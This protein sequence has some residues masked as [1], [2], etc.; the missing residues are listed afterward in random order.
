VFIGD[1]N[2]PDI[3]WSADSAASNSSREVMEAA[4]E[5]GLS[6]L[7]DFPTHKRGNVLD[8]ILTNIPG[9]MENIREEASIGR[10]DHV[11]I[12]SELRMATTSRAMIKAKNW[13][14]ADWKS[15][16]EGITNT[17][18]PTASDGCTVE[19]AWQALRARINELTTSFVPERE[20]RE[21]KSD[22][23][24][25][26][27]LQLVRK[28]R[29]MWKRARHG[30]NVAKYEDLARTVSKK[31]RTAK[32]QMEQKLAKDKTGN[33]KPFYNYIRKKTKTS[34]NV[35][36]LKNADGQLIKEPA[37]MAEELN[38]CFSDVFTRENVN[39]LP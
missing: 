15:I 31:I 39:N 5:A 27:I 9:R 33:K 28:K 24:T 2:L 30:Q 8:L 22:W 12:L 17:V 3:D 26:E 4:A 25:A 1:F 20:F 38:R 18:W 35:G 32:R 37:E 14:K 21:R 36:P 6:Q 7:V 29:R 23:M 16:K 10:S 13:G 11:T 34:E 19:E